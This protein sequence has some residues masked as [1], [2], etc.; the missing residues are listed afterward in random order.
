MGAKAGFTAAAR[1]GADEVS[2]G[3]ILSRAWG[4]TNLRD[5]LKSFGSPRQIRF[6][7]GGLKNNC[8]VLQDIG[9]AKR[10]RR[11]SRSPVE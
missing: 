2:A 9:L 3:A 10:L 6:G 1:T 5:T 11:N 4:L 8:W 7:A